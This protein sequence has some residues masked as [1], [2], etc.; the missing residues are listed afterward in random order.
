MK[1]NPVRYV[2]LDGLQS[3]SA[4]DGAGPITSDEGVQMIVDSYLNEA[5]GNVDNAWSRA[6]RDRELGYTEGST[7]AAAA[8]HYLYTRGDVEENGALGTVRQGVSIPLY[9][10]LKAAEQGSGCYVVSNP[11]ATPPSFQQIR[12]GYRGIR[13]G[14]KNR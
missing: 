12:W 3:S 11:N 9:A 14:Q 4:S 6:Q 5:G 2:D 1:N 8:E 7:V 10:T 13:D